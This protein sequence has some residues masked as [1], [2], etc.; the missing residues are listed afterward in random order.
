MAHRN[1][2]KT[3]EWLMSMARDEARRVVDEAGGGKIKKPGSLM[4]D[5]CFRK[6]L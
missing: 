6:P 1:N 5:F 2:W 4:G 3:V